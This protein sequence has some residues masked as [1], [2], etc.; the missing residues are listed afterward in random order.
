MNLTIAITSDLESR[1]REAAA[2]Q[3]IEPGEYVANALREHLQTAKSTV[4]RLSAAESRLLGEINRGLSE[5][6]WKRYQELIEKRRAE[7]LSNDEHA[8]LI[9]ISDLVERVNGRRIEC[10]TQLA[11]LRGTTLPK[12]MEQLGIEPAPVI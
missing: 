4:P 6:Q 2:S 11:A 7:Q 8:E 1:L 9:A 3:G 12:L 5:Q 10:L